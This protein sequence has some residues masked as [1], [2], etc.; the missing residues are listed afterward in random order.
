LAKKSTVLE[1]VAPLRT[2]SAMV[3]ERMNF[4]I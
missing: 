1:E 2:A 4:M 3:P